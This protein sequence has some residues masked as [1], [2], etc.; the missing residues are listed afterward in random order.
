MARVVVIGATGHI[1]GY[2]VPRLVEAGH[3]IDPWRGQPI[4]YRV[5]GTR[6]SRSPW[7]AS[8]YRKPSSARR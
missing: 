8:A 6:S 7:T 4:G 3:A 1:G 5:P 2:L